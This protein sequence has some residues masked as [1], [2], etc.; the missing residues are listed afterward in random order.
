[1]LWGLESFLKEKERC[2]EN[3]QAYEE[4]DFITADKLN[5]HPNAFRQLSVSRSKPTFKVFGN[6]NVKPFQGI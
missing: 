3:C 4:I 5:F 1:M 2:I 6:S